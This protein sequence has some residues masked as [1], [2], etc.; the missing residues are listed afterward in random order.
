MRALTVRLTDDGRREKVLVDDWTSD[1]VDPHRPLRADEVRTTT[2]YSGITNGTERNDLLGGNYAAP[3]AMLPWPNGYQN[4]GRVTEIGP[5]V[6]ELAIGD[7][8]YSSSLHVD[9]A[10]VRPGEL[11]VRLPDTVDPTHAAL[12]GM[13]SIALH[14]CRNAD[15]RL[16][17]TVLIVG[18]GIIG[19]LMAQI[20][21]T[22]GGRVTMCDL[23]DN[24]LAAARA[25]HPLIETVL[26]GADDWEELLGDRTF[27]GVMDAAGAP[28]FED[29][30]V[31]AVTPRGRLLFIAGRDRVDYDFNLGH[32]R[33]ITIKQ[34]RHFTQDDLE[35]LTGLVEAGVVR[36]GHLIQ[37]VVPVADADRI[38]EMLRDTPGEL[39]GTVFVW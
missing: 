35:T 20:A 31:R 27:D 29:R 5:E 24:R 6:T 28:G 14:S 23:D 22:M 26:L 21:L 1:H 3:E 13:A 11:V 9:T 30:L 33:E 7:M 19:Q 25:A 8:V 4:V 18:A 12:F 36:I 17:E 16:D 32:W 34:N 37:D 15:I 2:V 39:F 38:Y 10:I